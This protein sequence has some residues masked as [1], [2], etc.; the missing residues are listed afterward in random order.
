[1]QRTYIHPTAKVDP[2]AIIGEGCYIGP[3][4]I[5]GPGV[6]MGRGNRLESHCVIGAPPEHRDYIETP[7]LVDIGDCNVFRPFVTVDSGTTESTVIRDACLLLRGSHVGHDAKIHSKANLSC[8]VLIGGHTI[9][10][11]GANL[12]LG[13]IVHQ[14]QVVGPYAM[15]GMGS[16]ITKKQIIKPWTIYVGSPAKEVRENS[17]GLVR[18]KLTDKHKEY[19]EENFAYEIARRDKDDHN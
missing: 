2:S 19:L 8:N 17:V 7:G 3:Y 12:G 9:V 6:T 10:M 16:V 13:A 5:V 11:E 4:C 18:A 15:I 1:M 14:R